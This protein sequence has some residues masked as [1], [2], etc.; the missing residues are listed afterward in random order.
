VQR[1]KRHRHSISSSARASRE[2]GTGPDQLDLQALRRVRER[3][4]SQL[5]II[6]QI[7]AFL[8]ERGGS[9]HIPLA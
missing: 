6:N 3:L 2:A 5:T 9:P 7:R 1:S 4:T 8:L